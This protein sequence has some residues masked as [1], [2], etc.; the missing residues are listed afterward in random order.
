[1]NYRDKYVPGLFLIFFAAL[2]LSACTSKPS[3]TEGQATVDYDLLLT[4]PKEDISY[5][6]SVKPV[7][8]KRCVVCHGCYDAPCQLKLSSYDRF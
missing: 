1:M 7:L 5:N 8:E 4:L 3:V 2:L 6:K